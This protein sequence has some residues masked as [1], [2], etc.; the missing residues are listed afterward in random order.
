MNVE[1]YLEVLGGHQD[2]PNGDR[3][4]LHLERSDVSLVHS[5]ARQTFKGIP[6]T[7]K[8]LELSIQKIKKYKK[9]LEEANVEVANLDQKNLRMPLRI[10][11][12][13]KYVKIVNDTIEIRFPF[14]KRTILVIEDLK[15]VLTLDTYTHE[16]GTHKHSWA[17]SEQNVFHIVDKFIEKQ[18]DIDPK[19]VTCYNKC[20]EIMSQPDKYLPGIFDYDIKNILDSSKIYIEN[21]LGKPSVDN[22][23]M[24]KDRSQSLGIFYF[25][26]IDL[27]K[28]L[29]KLSTLSQRIVNRKS[30]NVF[31]QR[32]KYTLNSI[33]ETLVELDRFPL[34]VMLTEETANDEL[35][36]CFN[37][38]KGIV[39][40]SEVSV[41]FRLDNTT[42]EQEQ[43]NIFVKESNLNNPI[44]KNTKIVYINKKKIPKPVLQADWYPAAIL[45]YG[46]FR[47]IN[48]VQNYV[49]NFDLVI[50]YD[51]ER[52]P[53][54]SV[55]KKTFR[56]SIYEI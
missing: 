54:M 48:N 14:N 37:A 42:N 30:A 18:F 22:L 24:F 43:F 16:K 35:I 27:Q 5:L 31:V 46:S 19:L 25:D 55:G 10:I 3:I 51:K 13:S 52:T 38:F 1:D 2:T 47:F 17:L 21:A 50:H 29:V 49:N 9:V 32:S 26:P 41:M 20:K 11:D 44:D 7:D 40:P 34:L 45:Q 23:Y 8:Q 33:V 15:Q 28:S 36:T 4:S 56:E 12:R 53:F 6:L 39:S